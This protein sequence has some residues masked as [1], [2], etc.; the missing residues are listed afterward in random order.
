MMQRETGDLN[1][2]I[3]LIGDSNPAHWESDLITPFDPRHPIIHNIWTSVLDVIQ[4]KVYREAHLRI[5]T[6]NI[7]IRNAVDDPLKKPKSSDIRWSGSVEKEINNLGNLI[8]KFHPII[9][10]SF[11]AFS[12]EFMCRSVGV[13]EPHKYGSW[14]AKELG[15]AFTHQIE[16][17][18][19]NKTNII[20]LLHRSIS[21]GKYIESHNYFTGAKGVNYFNFVGKQ[22]AENILKYKE[23][24]PIWI[25]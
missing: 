2:P 17:F 14:G 12:Y 6:S 19:P 15:I 16:N 7:Y 23:Q 24:L 18:T 20:S 13:Q 3:W 22:L 1:F 5:D 9:L 8:K 10:V 4:D 11:G 25:R 21:G